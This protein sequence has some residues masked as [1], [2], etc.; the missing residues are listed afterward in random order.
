MEAFS[1]AQRGL[2]SPSVGHVGVWMA[3]CP[4]I[5][6]LRFKPGVSA[7][8]NQ[9]GPWPICWVYM[10]VIILGVPL[11]R[12]EDRPNGGCGLPG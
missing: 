3:C 12:Q 9:Y 5:L 10:L 4:H 1:L 7:L 6:S 11:A 8:Q 2:F